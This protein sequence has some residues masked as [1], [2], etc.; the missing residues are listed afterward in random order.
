MLDAFFANYVHRISDIRYGHFRLVE[1]NDRRGIDVAIAIR[2]DLLEPDDITVTSHREA[3]FGELGVFDREVAAFGITPESRVFNRDCLMV[4]LNMGKR[5]L[6]LFV[7]HLKSM[8]NGKDDGR[9]RHPA[10]APR[11]V[12]RGAHAGRAALRP[13][14]AQGAW[15]V[16]GDLNDYVERIGPN[17]EV[18]PAS[19]AASTRLLDRFAVNPV[20]S[21]PADERWT[22][23]HRA[24]S[25]ASQ[26]IRRGA[27]AA[28]LRAAVA[29]LLSGQRDGRD[30]PPGL[31]LPRAARPA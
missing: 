3:S 13:G 7:C 18:T 20:A 22:H 14:L 11:G 24:W 28:R 30:R 8:N 4:D 19:P 31:A 27:R 29:G 26:Q 10:A 12:A 23:F 16:A 25:E 21:L 6:T 1:G 9:A 2:R 5:A 17:G 15:I